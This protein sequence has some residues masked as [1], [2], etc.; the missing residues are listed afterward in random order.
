[1]AKEPCSPINRPAGPQGRPKPMP[2]PSSK[3]KSP[4]CGS[5]PSSGGKRK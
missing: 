4:G 5:N 1:M 2:M 3:P